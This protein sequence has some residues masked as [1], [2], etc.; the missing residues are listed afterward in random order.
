MKPIQMMDIEVFVNFFLIKFYEPATGQFYSYELRGKFSAFSTEQIAAIKNHLIAVTS[1]TFNGKKFD[2]PLLACALVGYCCKD[3]R[4][5]TVEIIQ[6]K[7]QPWQ[8]EKDHNVKMPHES[9]VD[10]I[11]LIEVAPGTGS[12]K[13]YGGRL[14]CR[15]MQD[16]PIEHTKE[17]TEDEMDVIAEYCGNDLTTTA[18]LY[19]KVKDTIDTRI[20]LTEQ[21]GVDMRSRSDAQISEAAI[22]QLLGWSYR[23]CENA[24]AEAYVAPGTVFYY[25]PPP[26][27]KFSTKIMQDTLAM[28]VRSPFTVAANGSPQ[29]SEELKNCR[30]QLGHSTYQFGVG[31]LHSTEERKRHVADEEYSLRDIDAD[32]FYPMI[33]SNLR[34]FPKQLG[35]ICLAI[36]R[37]WIKQRL[38]FKRSGQKR[39]SDTFKILLNGFFG[40]L[41]SVF[42][43]LFA[44]QLL[45]QTTV[46][47]QLC[48]AMLIEMLESIDGISVVSANTDGVVVKC[49][50]T[51][52]NVRDA[53]VGIWMRRCGFTTSTNDYLALFSRDVNS[54]IAVQLDGK[55]K[56][57][58]AFAEPG[59]QKNPTNIICVDAVKAYLVGGTPIEKT[60][61]RCSDIRKFV[62]VRTVGDKAGGDW[63]SETLTATTIKD[64][65]ADLLARGWTPRDGGWF[66]PDDGRPR[67]EY[68]GSLTTAYAAA[69][70]EAPRQHLGKAVRWYYGR[71]QTG[72]ITMCSSGNMV[73]RSE[74]AKPCMELPDVLPPD[75]NYDWYIAEAR[76]LL[77]DINCA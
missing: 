56:T 29:M 28:I 11:D 17:L 75:I 27:I 61:R 24:K 2:W 35:D 23:D 21:Y 73:A 15:H 70:A 39:K 31:G 62:T 69:Q 47:G 68:G 33:I 7:K 67:F 14:H 53:M 3:L 30:V 58:G 20:D 22:K 13:I 65:T 16:L 37:G 43:I 59:L 48:L 72:H 54:Y 40:K 63:V 10:H 4:A 51:K 8:I 71:G 64:R 26:F 66:G 5:V 6:Y 9:L 18:D 38:E 42:S 45:V 34:L 41:G 44:P 32:S 60:I 57:K 12:L 49:L 25:E 77:V 74:G 50:R 46:T 76:S 55:F 19:E 52:H 36:Y 1:V